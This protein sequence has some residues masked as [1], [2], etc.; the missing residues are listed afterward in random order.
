M[1]TV[2]LQKNERGAEEDILIPHI[3]IL[4]VEEVWDYVEV[5]AAA[6]GAP[7]RKKLTYLGT[8]IGSHAHGGWMVKDTKDSIEKKIRMKA[9]RCYNG[10][11]PESCCK[12][13]RLYLRT[14]GRKK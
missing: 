14:D 5:P 9:T 4:S 7:A 13:E 12:K 10:D 3:Q 1:I 11:C 8:H 2:T 6:E